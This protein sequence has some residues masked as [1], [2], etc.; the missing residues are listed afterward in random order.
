MSGFILG[1]RCQRVVM[2]HSIVDV[3]VRGTLTSDLCP[4]EILRPNVRMELV[5]QA[6]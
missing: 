2:V 1:T 4:D 6:S 3:V 5:H